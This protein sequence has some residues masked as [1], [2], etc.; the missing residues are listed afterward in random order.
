MLQCNLQSKDCKIIKEEEESTPTRTPYIRAST[1][2]DSTPRHPM[3][4]RRTQPAMAWHGVA[5]CG[6]CTKSRTCTPVACPLVLNTTSDS[7]THHGL[8]L[9]WHPRSGPVTWRLRLRS[10]YLPT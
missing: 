3:P 7:G 6:A 4:C 2:H 5:W 1:A 10:S 8:K 9:H